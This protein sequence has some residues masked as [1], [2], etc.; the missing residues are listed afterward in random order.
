[1]PRWYDVLEIWRQYASGPVSGGAVNSGHYLAEE[2][3]EEC[4]A[5]L[6]GFL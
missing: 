4:L 1:L 5:R 6:D 3:P 2:A